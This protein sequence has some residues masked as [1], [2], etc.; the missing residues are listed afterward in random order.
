MMKAAML[1][2]WEDGIFDVT[3]IPRLTVHDELDFSVQ[4]QT[5][6]TNEAFDEMRNIMQNVI[7]LRVP[8]ICDVEAGPNW[9]N[10]KDLIAA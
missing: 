3:G 9:G 6:Q 4:D 7:P 10:V 5:A 2:C 1:K 8:V